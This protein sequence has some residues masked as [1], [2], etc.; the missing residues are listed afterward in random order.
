MLFLFRVLEIKI[1]TKNIFYKK[2]IGFLLLGNTLGFQLGNTD[3]WALVDHQFSEN[4]TCFLT[5][6]P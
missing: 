5:N 3:G 2:L 4:T 6:F 1:L